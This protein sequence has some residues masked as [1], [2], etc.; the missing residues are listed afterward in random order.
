LTAISVDINVRIVSPS[1]PLPDLE[2]RPQVTA[3]EAGPALVGSRCPGCGTGA[4]P[5]RDVCPGCAHPLPGSA[6][7]G[8]HGTLYSWTTVHVSTTRP[9]P[10]DLGYVDL[11]DH[12]GRGVR[13]LAPLVG[14]GWSVGATLSLVEAE[15]APAGWAFA[16]GTAR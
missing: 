8:R 9:T 16:T 11:S 10:Y 6:V 2:D 7:L 13:V 14:G 15:E 4:F 5:S 1:F 3:T 12:E